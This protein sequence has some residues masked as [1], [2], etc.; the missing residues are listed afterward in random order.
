MS[1]CNNKEKRKQTQSSITGFQKSSVFTNYTYMSLINFFFP[2]VIKLGW[3][4]CS[5]C[6][7]YPAA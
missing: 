7:F 3:L 6:V 5:L 2:S 1:A 4:V